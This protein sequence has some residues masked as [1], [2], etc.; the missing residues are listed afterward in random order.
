MTIA[1]DI[2]HPDGMAGLTSSRLPYDTENVGGEVA[3]ENLRIVVVKE[4]K[5]SSRTGKGENGCLES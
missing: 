1:K 2:K 5:S 4:K 3:V